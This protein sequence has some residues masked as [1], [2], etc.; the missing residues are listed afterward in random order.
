MYKLHLP[1]SAETCHCSASPDSIIALSY[2][3]STFPLHSGHLAT[4]KRTSHMSA[5]LAHVLDPPRWA[6]TRRCS[7]SADHIIA[8]ASDAILDVPAHPRMR[9]WMSHMFS[10][11][12]GDTR[13]VRD[14]LK[15]VVARHLRTLSSAYGTRRHSTRFCSPLDTW[16]DVAL[17]SCTRVDTRSAQMG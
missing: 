1:R 2:P 16:R 8:V 6:E 12:G 13:S 17:V 3:T 7:T 11:L 10:A 5:A 9:E 14:G 4:H 15:H